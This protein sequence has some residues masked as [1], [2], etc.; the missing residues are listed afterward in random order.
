MSRG[1]NPQSRSVPVDEN[2]AAM[3][4]ERYN[5]AVIHASQSKI[6]SFHSKE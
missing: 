2:S 6:E 3:K 1:I 5:I 4:M